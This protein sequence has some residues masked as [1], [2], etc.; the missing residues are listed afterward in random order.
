MNGRW[1]LNSPELKQFESAGITPLPMSPTQFT[2]LI[3]ADTRWRT[4][5]N[6]AKIT[7]E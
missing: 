2:D 3:K 1:A 5:I 4:V 7:A 6:D